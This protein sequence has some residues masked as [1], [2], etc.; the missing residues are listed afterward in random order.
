MQ[1]ESCHQ[2]CY[3]P[4]IQNS[5]S[6][7][8]NIHL[9]KILTCFSINYL[10]GLSCLYF[11]YTT[12]GNLTSSVHEITAKM[13]QKPS[14]GNSW[15]VSQFLQPCLLKS[16]LFLSLGNFSITQI[17]H[18][19]QIHERLHA[20]SSSVRSNETSINLACFILLQLGNILSKSRQNLFTRRAKKKNKIKNQEEQQTTPSRALF[21]MMEQSYIKQGQ[22]KINGFQ[23]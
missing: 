18:Q 5:S 3:L 12:P 19:L 16:L 8:K 23:R 2:K 1:G 20:I 22:F 9:H 4:H 6:E 7:R 21:S 13:L 11:L 14:Q 15:L 10:K 17:N